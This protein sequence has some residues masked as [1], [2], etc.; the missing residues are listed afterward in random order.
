MTVPQLVDS[1][2]SARANQSPRVTVV[3]R[4]GRAIDVSGL[5]PEGVLTMLRVWGVT[6]A[7]IAHVSWSLPKPRSSKGTFQCLD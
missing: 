4:N 1:V 6:Y 5:T 2:R 3:L 7:E